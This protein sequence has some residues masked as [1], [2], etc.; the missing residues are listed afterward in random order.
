LAHTRAKRDLIRTVSGR[1]YQFTGE[2][3]ILSASPDERA[4]AGMAA[5]AQ[6]AAAL[7]PANLP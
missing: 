2:I 1:G 4:G 6:S 5:P 7:P 3:R